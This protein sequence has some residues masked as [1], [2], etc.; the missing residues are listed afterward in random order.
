MAKIAF[1]KL[2]A[3]K[4]IKL[5][6]ITFNDQEI[7]IFEYL[8]IEEKLALISRIV[9]YSL[10]DNNFANPA[11]LNIYTVL[12]LVYTYTN[13]SFTAKQRENFLDLYDTLMTSGL[14]NAIFEV[15]K[16]TGEYDYIQY[17]TADV[18]NEIYKYRDS[19]LGILN[20]VQQDYQNLDLDATKIKEKIANKENVEFLQDV[21]DKLG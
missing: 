21:M 7:E 14:W 19:V 6:K 12:E 5:R 15:L 2:N 8:P 18:V 1:T 4:N 11:R 13:I 9:N 20:A 10:D 3:K 17:T 16:E